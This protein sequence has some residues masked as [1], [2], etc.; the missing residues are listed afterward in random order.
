[1]KCYNCHAEIYGD[2]P[3]CPSCGA[4]IH[5][6]QTYDV[7]LKEPTSNRKAVI[8]TS[9]INNISVR[10]AARVLSREKPI[11][12][13]SITLSEATRIKSSYKRLG[14][15]VLIERTEFNE[16]NNDF[17]K[18][19]NNVATNNTQPLQETETEKVENKTYISSVKDKTPVIKNLLNLL[20]LF[21]LLVVIFA[22]LYFFSGY[23]PDDENIENNKS[24]N[25]YN[26]P[27]TEDSAVVEEPILDK[28]VLYNK[29]IVV[30]KDFVV[31]DGTKYPDNIKDA[32]KEELS[33]ENPDIPKI[34]AELESKKGDIDK[35][36]Y[37][38]LKKQI[39]DKKRDNRLN[40]GDLGE[41]SVKGTSFIFDTPLPDDTE[42]TFRV[43]T[44][45][46][47]T[48]L[49]E[50]KV[51]N[52]IASTP[53]KQK[54]VAGDYKIEVYLKKID[55]KLK[56]LNKLLD[57]L[58]D[59][60]SSSSPKITE[61]N[62]KQAFD[63]AMEQLMSA[64]A[65][66]DDLRELLG[67]DGIESEVSQPNE[68]GDIIIEGT[69]ED[70]IEFIARACAGIGFSMRTADFYSQNLVLKINGRI[71]KIPVSACIEAVK[72]TGGDVNAPQFY[73]MLEKNM[74]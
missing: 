6:E 56:E 28:D 8:L 11:I 59:M 64:Q 22:L 65:L 33:K 42:L 4:K 34:S 73:K 31:P 17:S 43:E 66:L 55:D 46:N 16:I 26:I 24:E 61:I 30:P 13:R 44:P 18:K 25:V 48:E 63:V 53:P 54:L 32:V 60:K 2:R 40:N 14:V 69:P 70:E 7:V 5:S 71:I 62:Y 38:S 45:K 72:I 47:V 36:D 39:N 51:K 3:F 10:R 9:D 29:N 20:W 15:D 35:K 57:G 49:Y 68:N 1:M 41:I 58:I 37:N 21:A 19:A 12:K 52:G 74:N 50:T 67:K 27:K 23:E